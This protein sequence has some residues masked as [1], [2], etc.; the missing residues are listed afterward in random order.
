M[1]ET[2]NPLAAAIAPPS[3]HGARGLLRFALSFTSP[4]AGFVEL[5]GGVIVVWNHIN[6]S[7]RSK[8]Q[9]RRKS[10]VFERG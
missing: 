6:G 5:R 10:S 9:K 1:I 2:L 4:N 7:V 8:Q 3:Y